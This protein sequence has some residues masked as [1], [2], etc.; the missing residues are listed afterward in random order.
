MDEQSNGNLHQN[1]QDPPG[2]RK[3]RMIELLEHLLQQYWSNPRSGDLRPQ[4]LPGELPS[5]LAVEVP[6]PDGSRL[7]GSAVWSDS[8]TIVFD[9]KLSQEEVLK[10]YEDRLIPQGWTKP[11]SPE[12]MMGGGFTM[13]ALVAD[14]GGHFCFDEQRV[15]LFVRTFASPGKPTSVHATLNAAWEQSLCSPRQQRQ[16][17]MMH[18]MRPMLPELRPPEGAIQMGGGSGGGG[19]TWTSN[20]WLKA[21]MELPAILNHYDEQL[22][23]AG[24]SRTDGGHA[25]PVAWSTWDFTSEGESRHGLLSIL[26]HTWDE[27]VYG[28][29]L[30]AE[31]EGY[32]RQ[33]G[34]AFRRF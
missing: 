26:E 7:V 2:N 30:Y 9:C 15:S 12:R 18:R 28:L 10:F 24:W 29:T 16:M 13:S 27:D 20:A 21:A 34:F 6:I 33:M 14:W 22:S 5:N 4:L 32:S 23:K 25:G 19:D 8:S 11:V 17:E 3:A 1:G 31:A